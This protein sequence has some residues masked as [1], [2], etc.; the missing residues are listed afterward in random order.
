LRGPEP[1]AEQILS[2]D[3]SYSELPHSATAGAAWTHALRSARATPRPEITSLLELLKSVVTLPTPNNTEFALALD[4]Y[5]VP[6]EGVDPFAW[7]NTEIADLISRG[8]Y[9]YKNNAEQQGRC[10]RALV[11]KLCAA[12]EVHPI[13]RSIEAV[14]DVPGHDRS[15]VSFGSRVA[16]T[17]AISRGAQFIRTQAKSSFRP[18]AKSLSASQRDEYLGNEFVVSNEVSGKTILIVDDVFRSGTSMASVATAAVAARAS[19][20]YGLCGVRTMRR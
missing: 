16:N 12:I 6:E 19:A 7:P 14:I 3:P 1:A 4:W 8:K 18:A 2:A 17:V 9:M 11:D 13:L 20:V 10:G 5:K 15:R